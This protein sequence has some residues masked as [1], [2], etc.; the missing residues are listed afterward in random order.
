[1]VRPSI[2]VFKPSEFFLAWPSESGSEL[3]SDAPHL[4]LVDVGLIVNVGRH[5]GVTLL[6]LVTSD[7]GVP[8]SPFSFFK[9]SLS[10]FW[11]PNAYTSCF[12]GSLS[13]KQSSHESLIRDP[14]LGEPKRSPEAESH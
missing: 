2:L 12:L 13:N 9:T 14:P 6:L 8:W 4:G 3:S 7:P 5:S 11:S 1:M 10:T